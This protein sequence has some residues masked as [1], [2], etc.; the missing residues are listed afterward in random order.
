[1]TQP[2]LSVIM[3][4]FNGQATLETALSSLAGQCEGLEIIAVDQGST[5]GSREI[6]EA[7][8]ARFPLQ[9]I[10]NPNG[11]SWTENT[12]FGLRQ[13]RAPLVTM[14]HQDDIWLPGR[15][16]LLKD[17]S[18]R[19]HEVDI[20]VHGADLIDS[21]GKTVGQMC[22]P[23]GDTPRVLFPDEALSHLI[24]QNT[25]ALPA[26]M[27]RRDIVLDRG[28]L[29]ETLWYTADWDLWLRLS[30]NGLAWNPR[31]ASAFRIHAKSLTM[32][33]SRDLQSF[34]RQLEIP[35]DRHLAELPD[36]LT[37]RARKRAEAAN[38]L[39]VCLAGLHHRDLRGLGAALRAALLLGPFEWRGFLRSTQIVQRLT[40]RLKLA[41]QRG[42]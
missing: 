7:A 37:T 42:A 23:F 20:W 36:Q 28:G 1:M 8:Q 33:G 24:V 26:V 27:F 14:L 4:I 5:D 40:P 30:R 3:P 12:N 11:R 41:M 21:Q 10:D 35:L 2:W 16:A 19:F 13:A 34:K 6:L 38:A 39:N 22:P 18:T 9:I 15:A 29:D 25:V 32:T 31:H 17:M